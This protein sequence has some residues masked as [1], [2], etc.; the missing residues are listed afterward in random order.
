MVELEDEIAGCGNGS[1]HVVINHRAGKM[2]SF[3]ESA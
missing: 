1:A 3:N 2:K